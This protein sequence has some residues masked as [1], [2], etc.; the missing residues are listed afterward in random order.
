M[1]YFG[2]AVPR[3]AILV[4]V[5]P[6]FAIVFGLLFWRFRLVRFSG[7]L[8]IVPVAV[9]GFELYSGVVRPQFES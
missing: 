5:W 9:L 6:L 2:L 4:A 3:L 7:W 8:A 1:C